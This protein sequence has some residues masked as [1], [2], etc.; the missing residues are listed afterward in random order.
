MCNCGFLSV[1]CE[2]EYEDDNNGNCDQNNDKKN[3][4]VTKNRQINNLVRKLL[5]N[6][7][8]IS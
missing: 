2:N 4:T 8:V 7:H 6:Y 5:K 3:A 1:C